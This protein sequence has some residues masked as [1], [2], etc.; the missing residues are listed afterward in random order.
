MFTIPTA[1]LTAPA[2]GPW[3]PRAHARGVTGQMVFFAFYAGAYSMMS[4]LRKEEWP[5][6]AC[7]PRR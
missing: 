2:A 3:D 5:L 7:S 6:A 1:A 4:I